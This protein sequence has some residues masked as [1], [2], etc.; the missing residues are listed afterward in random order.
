MTEA[1][2][3]R[4]RSSRTMRRA[5]RPKAFLNRSALVTAAFAEGADKC[6]NRPAFWNERSGRVEL[7]NKAG[8]SVKTG[9]R[10]ACI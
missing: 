2:C 3:S 1:S 4:G 8:M 10:V 5:R 6:E 9:D 7:D